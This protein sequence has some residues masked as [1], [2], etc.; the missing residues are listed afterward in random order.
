M[1][2]EFLS[3]LKKQKDNELFQLQKE[4]AVINRDLKSVE[5]D[6]DT[7]FTKISQERKS[8]T[9]DVD[10]DEEGEEGES[11]RYAM[12]ANAQTAGVLASTSTSEVPQSAEAI[13]GFN[14]GSDLRN[15]QKSRESNLEHRRRRMQAHF[16][17]LA[18][19]YFTS[20]TSDVLFPPQDEDGAPNE[21]DLMSEGLDSFSQC[22][23]K[24]TRYNS[25]RP[26]ATL[27]F[28]SDIFN[29]ASIVSSIE[30]DKDNE[31]F[32]IAG[33][34]KRIKIYDY[35]VVLKD[36]VDLHYPSMEM[37][38]SSKI[39]CVSWNSF[40]KSSLVSSDY[41]G[42]VILWDTSTC[43]RTKVFQVNHIL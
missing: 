6:I 42:T 29:N 7:F 20:R 1:L 38:C 11:A 39:S 37:S 25:V 40:Q 21:D 19:C 10:D 41:D 31:F 33:V 12:L 16:D 14:V 2:K 15:L 5:T 43:Q 9:H 35:Y 22:L 30:F 17:D 24:F 18:E 26:L 3:H 27:S 34:T 4:A 36:M 8:Q 13:E 23:S 28:T 32:A